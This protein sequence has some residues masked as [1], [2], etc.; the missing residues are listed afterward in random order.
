M[1]KVFVIIILVVSFTACQNTGNKMEGNSVKPFINSEIEKQVGLVYQKM[2]LDEKVAQLSG[3]RPVDLLENN[4]LSLAKCREKIPNG[5]G[6]VCQYACGVDM[7]PDELRDFVR[8][9]QNYLIN[10][11][12]SGIPA[13]FHEEAITGIA[14]KG[15]TV[16]PQQLGVACTWNTE[17][18]RLKTEQ[19][20]EAMRA[21]GGMLALSPM[22]DLIYTAHWSRI[23]ES[24]GEDSYL[25]AA[26][27]VAFVEG[28]QK[29]GIRNGVAACSKHFLGYGGG[30]SLSTKEL[31]EEVLMPHEAMIKQA[32]SKVVM[33]SY[34]RFRSEQAVSS[35]TLLKVMLRGYLGFD[36]IVVSDYGAVGHDAKDEEMC[37]QRAVEA[38]NAGNDLEFPHKHCYSYLPQAMEKG[39]VTEERFEE[40]VKRALALKANLGLLDENPKLYEEG[41]LDLDKPEY[42]ETSYQLA[43]QSV[44]MLK[45]N[46]ILPLTGE[47][48]QIALVGPNANTYWC[49]LGDYTYQSMWA[50]WW[51]GKVDPNNPKIVGLYE[52]FQN[53]FNTGA[54]LRYERGCDWSASNESSVSHQG[55][56]RTERLKMMLLE[57]SDETNW[58]NAISIAANSDVIIAALGENPT[59]CGEARERK[60]I[61]L[62]G[63]QEKFLKELI[64][65]GKPVVLVMFGGRPQVVSDVEEGCAAILQAWYPGEEGGNAVADILLGK[66]NPSGKLCVSY[67][68]TEA[69]G[70]YCYNNGVESENIA[71]P[72]GYG[73]SYTTFEYS[74]L[75]L[76]CE[77]K[78]SSETIEVSCKV[79]NTGNREG[80][81][82]VQLYLSPKDNQPLKPIQLKGFKRVTLKPGETKMVSFNVSPQQLAHYSNEQWSIDPGG[83]EFKIG[84]SSAD[85]RL[86]GTF[87][88]AGKPLQMAGRSV[89]FSL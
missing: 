13:I 77:A 23:E 26:M 55:D 82:I 53:K 62:P 42:R 45:N 32:G 18:A 21:V 1:R 11:T 63:D 30:S 39:L 24:Y 35:D 78:T 54:T 74:D 2:T 25:S 88:L 7:G 34:G 29:K 16:Y 61:R 14:A 8:D 81:E 66:V 38:I 31:Y 72:F 86:N 73:L 51:G 46:G 44:V 75:A 6:H 22:V 10:E 40:A 33:T 43:C 71:Y 76:S 3:I 69:K 57:T 50:F 83:Y 87:E 49:M 85:I 5:I 37:M 12:P 80:T 65:T 60:G 17:L 47:T 59:L 67:P 79:T 48:K 28:L 19:T 4:K 56:P 20:A 58:E 36:G 68:K 89:F 9:L 27:G 70:L 64:A 41:K 15:A 84:A 52:A